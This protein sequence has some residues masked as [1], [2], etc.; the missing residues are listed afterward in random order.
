MLHFSVRAASNQREE[1]KMP[2]LKPFVEDDTNAEEIVAVAPR[3]L[4]GKCVKKL[5]CATAF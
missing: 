4:I 2:F 3:R 1:R 5:S